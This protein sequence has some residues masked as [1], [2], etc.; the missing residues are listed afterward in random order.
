MDCIFCMIKDG[1]IP[2]SKVY[3]D[4][5]I[6]AFN[7]VNPGAPVHVLVIPKEHIC[8][9]DAINESNSS[10]VAKIFEKIPEIA[11]KAGATNGYRV[12]TNCGED[13]CQSGKHLHFHVMGGAKLSE[14]MS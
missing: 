4:D 8:C 12:V 9:A 3:E 13:G 5:T 11:K 10:V 2:T 6:L 14:K 1:K 7:D